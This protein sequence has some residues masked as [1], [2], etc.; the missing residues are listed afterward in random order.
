MQGL[1]YTNLPRKIQKENIEKLYGNTLNT[2]VSRLEKYR[3]CPFSY[4]LEYGLKLKEKEQLKIQSFNTG[5]FMHETI[6]EF[7]EMVKEENLDLAQIDEK[8]ILEMVSK[9]MDESLKLSKNFVFTATAKYKVL[10][11]RLKRIVAKALKYIIETIIYSDFQVEGTEIEFGKKGQYEPIVLQLDNGKRVEIT[12]K[13]DRIDTAK[14]EDGKY[15]RI[16]DYKSSAK[17]IDLNEVYAGLQIQLLTY[18]DAIVKQEDIMPAGIFYFSLLEQMVKAEKRVSEEEI[19][20]MIRKNFKMKG[21]IIADVK[22]IKMNDN[23]LKSGSSKLVPAALTASGTINEKWTNGVKSEEFKILQEYIYQTIKEIAD[24]IFSGK[25]DVKPYNKK[26]K[27]P[28]EYCEYKPI[29]GFNV[30]EN[31]NEYKYIDQKS[32]DEILLKMKRKIQK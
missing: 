30:K 15:L 11:K 20:E 22:I 10:V 2:S 23:T 17:N 21:L 6:D 18:T 16:I 25:I 12:G 27:T 14:G 1:D 3:S 28:C 32:K 4:Y 31:H 29:C 19:E 26:G 24:E 8:Q 13:I 7:F 5:S 9:I